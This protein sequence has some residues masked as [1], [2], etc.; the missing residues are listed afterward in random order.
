MQVSGGGDVRNDV[1]GALGHDSPIRFFY[2]IDIK[3][4]IFTGGGF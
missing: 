3:G 4:K 1:L 2:F